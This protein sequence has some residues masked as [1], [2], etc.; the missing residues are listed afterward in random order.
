MLLY[1]QDSLS[2]TI[3]NTDI[4]KAEGTSLP[5]GPVVK[6]SPSNAEA[7][8]LIPGQG[9]RISH[10]LQPKKT[11]TLKKTKKNRSRGFPDGPVVKNLPANANVGDVGLISGPGRFHRPLGNY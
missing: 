9:A 10:V 1:L 5:G 8:G 6:T 2:I 4:K 7:A 3:E 11:K